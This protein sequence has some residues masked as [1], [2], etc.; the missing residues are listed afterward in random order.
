MVE[1][2][3]L[4][5]NATQ[6]YAEMP[7]VAKIILYVFMFILGSC[8]GSFLN[9]IIYRLPR[10]ISVVKG[11]SFCPKC[12]HK[13]AP[14][15]L[16]PFFS[17][18]FLKRKCRYCGD[19]IS[20]RYPL[21]ELAG[22]IMAILP[23]VFIKF[24][25]ITEWIEWPL[26]YM[27]LILLYLVTMIDFDTMTIPNQLIIALIVPALFAVYVDYVKFGYA[28]SFFMEILLPHIIGFFVVSVPMWLITLIKKEAIGG[29]DIKLMA[30]CGFMLG[31]KLT[32]FAT[33]IG[34]I[35]GGIYGIVLLAQRKK[36]KDG[37]FAFGP[38]LS[39]GIIIALLVNNGRLV[40]LLDWYMTLFRH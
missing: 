40:E 37:H 9:V 31:W 32:L 2:S 35:T 6:V 3:G 17:W 1:I 10:G 8:I 14:M 36:G 30:V 28:D 11:H 22:G 33:F 5:V 29:G 39:L 7:L 24:G 18:I 4:I 21:A 20:A 16:V 27:V 19:K 34:I 26:V 15:D 25:I 12:E 38:F 13:L 23:L